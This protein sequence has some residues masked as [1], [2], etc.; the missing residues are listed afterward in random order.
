MVHGAAADGASSKSFAMDCHGEGWVILLLQLP[1]FGT[2]HA[3]RYGGKP[4][5]NETAPPGRVRVDAKRSL[6]DASCITTQHTHQ[7]AVKHS[8]VAA[9][10]GS[11]VL[12][13]S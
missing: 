4:H 5:P 6:R 11:F 3:R 1:Y 7:D 13:R 12:E 10:V 8:G 2:T 9:G